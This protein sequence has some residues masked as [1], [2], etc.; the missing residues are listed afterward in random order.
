MISRIV[1]PALAPLVKRLAPARQDLPLSTWGLSR[2][3][4][5][6]L[7]LAGLSLATLLERHGSPLHVVDAARLDDNVRDF[8]AVPDG[9]ARGAEITYSFK[10]NPVPGV[11]RRLLARGVGAEVISEYELWLALTLGFPPD[12][13]VYNGPA[14]SEAS[15]RTALERSIGLLN[16]N[17]HCEIAPF[18]AMARQMGRRPR[19]GVRVVVPGAWSGQLGERIDTGAAMRAFEEAVRAPELDVVALH[20]HLGGEIATAERLTGFV[21]QVLAFSDELHRRLSLDIELLDLGGSLACPTVRS[22]HLVEGRLNRTF[23][24]ELLPRSP[25]EVL[26]IREAVARVVS[27]VNDH[28]RIKGRRLPRIVLEPGRALTG[29]T[30]LLLTKVVRVH[31]EVDGV[32]HAVLDA[33]MCVASPVPNEI[34]QLFLLGPARG[35]ERFRYRLA[36]P[37]CSPADVLYASIDLPRL[38]PGDG[39]A[40]MD[41]GAYFVPFAASFSFAQP[42][43]VMVEAGRD[44]VLRRRETFQHMTALDGLDGLGAL[45][46]LD[47]EAAG[48]RAALEAERSEAGAKAS[49]ASAPEQRFIG[50]H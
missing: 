38:L 40:I 26:S 10:T 39:L 21:R 4:R 49:V 3:E 31:D 19:V 27:M 1:K 7:S 47:R 28:F 6:E 35:P 44:T 41:S 8:Q 37:I 29:N 30:Q 48:D 42:G 12:H 15:L 46:A 13:I 50:A 11:L 14:K 25:A 2:S 16:F 22:L 24:A 20:A 23:G 33:G 36:G 43:I 34:H 9:A 17:N 32:R 18:A 45:D 5:G